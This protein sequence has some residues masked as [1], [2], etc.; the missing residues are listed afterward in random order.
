MKKSLK[1]L[2]I[3]PLAATFITACTGPTQSSQKSEDST[4]NSNQ[5][6]SP[7]SKETP[8]TSSESQVPEVIHVE[9]VALNKTSLEMHIGD[10]EDLVASVLPENADDKTIT[11]ST[12]DAKTVSVE[13]GHII[14]LK[15][16]EATITA[17]ST[18]GNKKATC[19]IHVLEDM[20]GFN[21]RSGSGNQKNF[22][23]RH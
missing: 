7:S 1:K 22:N 2:F 13:N 19:A 9:S 6:S 21:I 12:S 15:V 23:P 3:V 17:T 5:P 14:A 20:I 18:D 8:V 4:I 16:G 10:K 11:W